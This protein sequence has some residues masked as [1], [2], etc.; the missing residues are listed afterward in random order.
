MPAQSSACPCALAM[1]WRNGESWKT[2]H[3]ECAWRLPANCCK[4]LACH[5]VSCWII[6]TIA[7][8]PCRRLQGVST[9]APIKVTFKTVQGN[10]FELDLES[11]DKVWST[12]PADVSAVRCQRAGGC[13]R[14]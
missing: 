2:P 5:L 14:S 9:M 8:T 7:L 1:S 12:F 13:S 10:K 4:C 3:R 6:H 11:T